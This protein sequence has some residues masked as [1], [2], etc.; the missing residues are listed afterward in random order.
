MLDSG[1]SLGDEGEEGDADVGGD[2]DVLKKEFVGIFRPPGLI[3]NE[4]GL[5]HNVLS[6]EMHQIS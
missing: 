4:S 5:Q 6:A 1:V 3:C 2:A